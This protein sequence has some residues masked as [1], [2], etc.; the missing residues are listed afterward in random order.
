MCKCNKKR[1]IEFCMR[2]SERRKKC[3]VDQT[4]TTVHLFS[5]YAFCLFIY[6]TMYILHRI[7]KKKCWHFYGFIIISTIITIVGDIIWCID[8]YI[9]P[10]KTLLNVKRFFIICTLKCPRF[11][12]LV[13]RKK[14]KPSWHR[15]AFMVVWK[16]SCDWCDIV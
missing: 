13:K 14:M 11:F 2:I 1:T 16:V 6:T 5:F 12:S 8:K 7:R 3:Q 9:L 15:S 10:T 4:R